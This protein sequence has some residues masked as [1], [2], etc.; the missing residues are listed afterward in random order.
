LTRTDRFEDD[1]IFDFE[2]VPGEK[3]IRI[4]IEEEGEND[5]ENDEDSESDSECDYY[6]NEEEII[7]IFG[8][9]VRRMFSRLFE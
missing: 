6:E 5:G 1:S 7:L 4:G 9:S 2:K 3:N 8:C